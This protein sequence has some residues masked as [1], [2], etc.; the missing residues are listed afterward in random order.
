MALETKN[1]RTR[2]ARA[3]H[4]IEGNPLTADDERLFQMFEEKGWSTEQQ[5][6]Y[7]KDHYGEPVPSAAE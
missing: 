3:V 1:D 4:A 7:L 2:F 6:A 5:I